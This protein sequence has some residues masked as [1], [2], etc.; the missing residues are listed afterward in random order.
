MEYLRK[1]EVYR[2]EILQSWCCCVTKITTDWTLIYA[3]WAHVILYVRRIFGIPIAWFTRLFLIEGFF[4]IWNCMFLTLSLC[5]WQG[6]TNVS[7]F[8]YVTLFLAFSSERDL[9]PIFFVFAITASDY[10]IIVFNK[11]LK[12]QTL[13]TDCSIDPSVQMSCENYTY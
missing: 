5:T 9:F 1:Y 13:L 10:Q 7:T 4:L 8:N 12:I 11:I 3:H 2:V 6:W